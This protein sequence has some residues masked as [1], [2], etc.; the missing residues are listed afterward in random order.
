[1]SQ[2]DELVC[3]VMLSSDTSWVG[4]TWE[5]PLSGVADRNRNYKYMMSLLLRNVES[6]DAPPEYVFVGDIS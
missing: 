4:G 1:M 3:Y 6:R 5:R 2:S